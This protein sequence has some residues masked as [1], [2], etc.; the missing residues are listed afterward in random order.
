MWVE[1]LGHSQSPYLSLVMVCKAT[2]CVAAGGIEMDRGFRSWRLVSLQIAMLHTNLP[3][4]IE[5]L[6]S[7]YSTTLSLSQVRVAIY[8]LGSPHQ[9]QTLMPNG[10]KL[11]AS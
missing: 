5:T 6:E 1:G 10:L 8:K 7:L 3:L 9:K 4:E 11:P 2:K